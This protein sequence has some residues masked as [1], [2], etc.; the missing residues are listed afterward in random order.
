MSLTKEINFAITAAREAAQ[1]VL[2]VYRRDFDVDLK[3]RR[4]PVT[5]ADRRANALLV[6]RFA[7]EFPNDGIVAEESL[8]SS[9]GELR[10][11][12]MKERI[13]F[14]DPLDGTKEFIAR[15]GEFSVMIGLVIGGRPVLGV[16]AMPESGDVAVGEV[17]SGA[18]LL[19]SSGSR[20]ELR[21]SDQSDRHACTVIVSRS[22]MSDRLVSVIDA[23]APAQRLRCGSVG[24]KAVRI[25][26][27][28]A[29]AY[30]NLH[31]PGGAKL[32]DGCAPEA[33]VR[34]SGG[35]TTD[36]QGNPID[37]ATTTLELVGGYVAT[38]G[39][40]HQSIIEVTREP[41]NGQ[42]V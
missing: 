35:V 32:W 8:P 41:G 26:Q 15:N 13:W 27:R 29:D 34:A 40:L 31:Q 6:E 24:V 14:I 19:S 36:L 7:T 25:A 42:S 28:A 20:S 9:I 39:H 18:W 21:V 17:G 37:Y 5:L 1:V 3:D 30:V 33:I 38:N 23:I 4:E 2:G 10:A 12:V 22:H 16:V 11:E